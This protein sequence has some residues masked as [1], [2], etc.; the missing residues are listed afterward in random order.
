MRQ[1]EIGQNKK[2]WTEWTRERIK[3]EMT[4]IFQKNGQ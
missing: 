3:T 1:A 2:A 4:A